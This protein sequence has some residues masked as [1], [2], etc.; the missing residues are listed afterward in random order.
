M[1][2]ILKAIITIT[3]N[4]DQKID[5]IHFE[6]NRANSVGEGLELFVATSFCDF[7]KEEATLDS[8]FS[9]RGAKNNPPDF[10]LKNS[11]AIEVKK[12][13]TDTT[14]IQLNSSH[15][16]DK[17]Y[18]NDPKMTQSA[19]DCEK[20]HSKDLLYIVGKLDKSHL[21]NIWLVYGDCFVADKQI[22]KNIEKPIKN[23]ISSLGNTSL[24]KELG[25]L[26]NVD[27]LK[28]SSLRVRGMWLL[29]NPSNIFSNSIPSLKETN[30]K[31][32]SIISLDKYNN[33]PKD[34]IKTIENNKS[35]KIEDIKIP[36]PNNPAMK[37]AVK[38]IL[39]R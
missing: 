14:Q 7:K 30:Y 24:T 18:V 38:L 35:L 26:N 39:W 6:N 33:F 17:I 27:T 19:R 28:V 12:I 16:K 34:D 32:V 20:W 29:Q 31:L 23:V 37:I 13:S 2:N 21:A 4:F 22:Y 36:N 8:V 3:E 11:D 25:R 10:I 1:S 9:Y 15:P 5:A